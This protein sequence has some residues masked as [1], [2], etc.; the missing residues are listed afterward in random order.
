MDLAQFPKLLPL[1]LV[2]LL[3]LMAAPAVAD[4]VFGNDGILFDMDTVIEFEFLG[5]DGVYQSTFGVMNRE[6]GQ[7]FPLFE[8]TRQ[9]TSSATAEASAQT[10]NSSRLTE[11]TFQAN[12]PYSFYLESR[13]NNQPAGVL[14]SSDDQN[15]GDRQQVR[16]EGGIAG[17]VNGG[18]MI[19]WDDTG[20]LLV[21]PSQQD[22]DFD[23]FTVRAGGYLSCPYTS[24][25]SEGE[26]ESFL[27]ACQAGE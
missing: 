27:A 6:T 8:E 17:L 14:Y 18:T 7:R 25:R 22:R 1:T 16:F 3:G 9:S 11:F 2:S 13:Y 15:P 20:S 26:S 21:P 5:S 4:D 23:D 10:A 19:Y 12:T 24:L